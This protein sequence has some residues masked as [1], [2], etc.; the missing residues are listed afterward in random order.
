MI[1]N[2]LDTGMSRRSPNLMPERSNWGSPEKPL[3]VGS[4]SVTNFCLPYAKNGTMAKS[5]SCQKRI[6]HS[7]PA[8]QRV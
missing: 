2:P 8:C 6:R 4:P 3:P 1:Q 5:E 7:T